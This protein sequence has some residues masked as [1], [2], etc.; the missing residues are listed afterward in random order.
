MS[1]DLSPAERLLLAELFRLSQELSSFVLRTGGAEAD[2]SPP[3]ADEEWWLGVRLSEFGAVLR[4]RGDGR[5]DKGD[6]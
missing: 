3:T 2:A 5:R 4:M 1:E 6:H